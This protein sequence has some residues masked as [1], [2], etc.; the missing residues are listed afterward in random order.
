M[1]NILFENP[2][3][4]IV[5]GVLIPV[6]CGYAW[7]KTNDRRWLIASGATFV[8]ALALFFLERNVETDQEKLRQAVIDLAQAVESNDVQLAL[9]KVDPSAERC[10][11]RI[12]SEMPMYEFDMCNVMSMAP[13]A[14][15]SE[16]NPQKA[17][18]VFVVWV[19]VAA[20]TYSYE[21]NAK[22]RVILYYRK[23][24]NGDWK[25]YDYDHEDPTGDS[26]YLPEDG[27]PKFVT[28]PE[29]Y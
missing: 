17:M 6:G 15:D 20:P 14:Y 10:R 19:D 18:I 27:P 28:E 22:R 7:M 2:F 23:D 26:R 16:E 3:W 11:Q 1:L 9:S 5:L 24:A 29:R 13:P 12:Q 4:I 8:I 25:V 21:G